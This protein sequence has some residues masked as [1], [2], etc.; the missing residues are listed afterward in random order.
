MVKHL[1]YKIVD[2]HNQVV[3]HSYSKQNSKEWIKKLGNGT[4]P[5]HIKRI[6]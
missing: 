3:H 4:K 2:D 1:K 5:Y 6:G